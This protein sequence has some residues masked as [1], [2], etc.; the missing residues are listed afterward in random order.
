MILEKVIILISI[1]ISYFLQ[2]SVD[3]FSLGK[4]KPDLLLILTVFFALYRGSFA[5]LWVGFLGG[6]LQDINLG[7]V[8]E[9]ATEIRFYIGTHALPKTLIGFFMGKISGKIHKE[10]ALVLF[11]LHLSVTLVKGFMEF[12]EVALFHNAKSAQTI[13]SIIIPEAVYT[14]LLS[15]FWFKVLNWAMPQD[16]YHR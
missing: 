12:F 2:T 8:A 7:G 3:F 9:S 15:I 10:G 5:G 11:M 6:L 16:D 4:I 14:A 1:L 13:V